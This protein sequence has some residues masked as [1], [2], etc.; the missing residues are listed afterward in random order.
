MNQKLA[1]QLRTLLILGRVSNLPTVWSNCL[2]GWWLALGHVVAAILFAITLIGL[3]LAW[4][5]LKLAGIS[6]APIG[7]TVVDSDVADAARRSHAAEQLAK[8][9]G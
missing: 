3:P 7:K 4:A 8:I 2:A 9:R 5:H 6:L 1:S